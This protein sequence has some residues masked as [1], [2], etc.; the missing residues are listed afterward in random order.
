MILKRP[1]R[2]LLY[3]DGL[4]AHT[5]P[6]FG[7]EYGNLS[8][9]QTEEELLFVQRWGDSLWSARKEVL[10]YFEGAKSSFHK[11]CAEYQT[12]SKL[13]KPADIANYRNA[14]RFT[15]S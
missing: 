12:V 15:A 10:R 1:N 3:I 7:E 11:A 6:A 13:D 8:Q 5:W 2:Q 4:S 14:L 9:P